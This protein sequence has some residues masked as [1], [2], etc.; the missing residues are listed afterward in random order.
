MD[1]SKDSN[2]MPGGL[3]AG[4]QGV[5]CWYADAKKTPKGFMPTEF[6]LHSKLYPLITK[7]RPDL[8]NYYPDFFKCFYLETDG[9]GVKQ[10]GTTQKLGGF[11]GMSN[12]MVVPKGK[13][14][15]VSVHE[16]LHSFDV[17]IHSVMNR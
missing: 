13:H 2:F 14:D 6:Y 1:L 5:I 10:D 16:L 11:V 15:L 9:F 3:Y 12:L 7:N 4:E 8:K 17:H